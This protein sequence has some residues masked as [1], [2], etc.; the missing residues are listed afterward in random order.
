[1]IKMSGNIE[2]TVLQA[3]WDARMHACMQAGTTFIHKQEHGDTS[4]SMHHI[5]GWTSAHTAEASEIQGKKKCER[6]FVG[7]NTKLSDVSTGQ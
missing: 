2:P 4:S 6:F 3:E 1:M 5:Q 7:K